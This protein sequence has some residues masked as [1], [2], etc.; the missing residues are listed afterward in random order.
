[1]VD[2]GHYTVLDTHHALY[3]HRTALLKAL[4]QDG[5]FTAALAGVMLDRCAVTVAASASK[6]TPSAA[7][8]AAGCSLLGAVTLSELVADEF[9]T[10][11][12]AAAAG[13]W[14]YYLYVRVAPQALH[15][16]A[17]GRGGSDQPLG[18]CRYAC[19]EG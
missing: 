12:A 8:V 17:G 5:I 6:R 7:E 16:G 15:A 18:E 14:P 3:M 19:A 4:Q 9:A 13:G 10:T 11:A 2:G 1:M